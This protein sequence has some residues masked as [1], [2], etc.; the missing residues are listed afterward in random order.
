MHRGMQLLTNSDIN[1]VTLPIVGE[2]DKAYSCGKVKGLRVRVSSTGAK[3]FYLYYKIAGKAYK[4]RIDAFGN[5]GLPAANKAAEKLK[6]EIALGINPQAVKIAERVQVKEDKKKSITLRKFLDAEYYPYIDAHQK[7]P[8]RTKWI[9]ERNFG[10]AMNKKLT[11]FDAKYI[12]GWR[13][14]KLS[15]GIKPSTTNRA[16]TAIKACI[17]SAVRWRMLD[18]SSLEGVGKLRVDTKGVIRFLSD[19]EETRLLAALDA[20]ARQGFAADYIR[21][22]VTLL[23]NTGARPNEAKQLKWSDINFKTRT[24]TLR[25]SYTKSGI[26]RHIPINDKLLG[27][28]KSWES[29][30]SG[31]WVFEG[32][33]GNAIVSTQKPW[34][35]VKGMAK[36]EDFRLYDLRHTFASKLAM[37]GVDLYTIAELLGHSNTEMTKIYAHLSEGHIR[38]AVDLL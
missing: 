37:K 12:E 36:L 15:S 14:E 33:N 6:A 24:V 20:Y 16:L 9:L 1:T 18:K 4:Y 19:D 38:K 35:Y 29:A 30:R 31:V 8:H 11:S 10:K 28:L 34:N 3:T 22:F 21:P 27:V 23:L 5:I 26:S 32:V 17:N 7:S 2:G 13:R 25:A